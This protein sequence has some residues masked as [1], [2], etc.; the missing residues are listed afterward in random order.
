[1]KAMLILLCL[2]FVFMLVS[3]P[4]VSAQDDDD[5]RG[6]RIEE[7]AWDKLLDE[8]K[9]GT[10]RDRMAACNAIG[11]LYK[12][13]PLTTSP[14]K[15]TERLLKILNNKKEDVRVR[16]AAGRAITSLVENGRISKKK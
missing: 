6:A 5:D 7:I 2:T 15:F 16:R 11:N 9:N 10:A 1:M 4:I 8:L 12:E 14:W 3:I 13:R